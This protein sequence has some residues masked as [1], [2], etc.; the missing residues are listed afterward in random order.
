MDRIVWVGCALLFLAGG[1]YFN[2]LPLLTWKKEIS[3]G[4]I[5][6]GLSAIAAAFAAYASWKAANIS[7]QSAEDSKLF[8]RAQ[9]YM[10]HRQDFLDLI[11]YLSGELDIVFVRK[12]ELYQRL[13]PR[14]HYSGNHFDVDGNPAVLDDWAEKYK[15]IIKM[16]TLDLSDAQLEVW[17]M[18]CGKMGEDLQFE[19][20]PKKGLKIFLFAKTPSDSINTG[21]TFDPARQVFHFGE[22]MN[23]IYA[24]CG[25][26]QIRPLL[27]DGHD[28][29]IKFKEYFIKIK[30]GQTCHRVFDPDVL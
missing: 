19:F 20:K 17:I 12:Y 5:V 6:G 24:F 11:D 25:Y 26:Q 2:I 21:F 9:L 16:T 28:F 27:M 7:K 30:S 1:V 8:T 15:A 14:N 13:F 22:V 29:Q 3:A 23:R 18:A 4:D 10:S